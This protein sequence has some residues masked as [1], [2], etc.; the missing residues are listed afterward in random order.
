MVS[1]GSNLYRRVKVRLPLDDLTAKVSPAR[2]YVASKLAVLLFA[3]ELDRRFR[4]ARSPVRS[5]AAHPGVAA[6]PMQQQAHGPLQWA[7]GR[8]LALALG[9]SADAGAIP[10]LFAATAPEVPAGRFLGPS[11]RKRDLRV[12]AD[13]LRPPAT[14]RTLAH[15]LWD[16]SEA[17]TGVRIAPEPIPTSHSGPL[18]STPTPSRQ[19]SRS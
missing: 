9:R 11:L 5:L 16:L 4:A 2:A 15:R 6:T 19:V 17:A 7:A 13:P 3:V 10:L 18:S 12:H 1:V 8:A 14:D